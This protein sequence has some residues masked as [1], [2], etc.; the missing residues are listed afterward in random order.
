MIV[1]GAGVRR[2]RLRL[3]NELVQIDDDCAK[4][5]CDPGQVPACMGNQCGCIPDIAPGDVGRF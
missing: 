3:D 5:M 2:G 4:M 1:S